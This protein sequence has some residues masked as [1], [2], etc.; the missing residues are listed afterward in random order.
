MKET[1]TYEKYQQ[2]TELVNKR[3]QTYNDF[4]SRIRSLLGV[5]DGVYPPAELYYALNTPE[6][7][8]QEMIRELDLTVAPAPDTLPRYY[9]IS[10][11]QASDPVYESKEIYITALSVKEALVYALDYF[12]ILQIR[13]TDLPEAGEALYDLGYDY[14]DGEEPERFE[15]AGEFLDQVMEGGYLYTDLHIDPI[16]LS[17][18]PPLTEIRDRTD[19]TIQGYVSQITME[20]LV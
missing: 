18:L 10:W 11:E 19:T 6:D 4:T 20:A 13:I 7:V 17:D 16:D 5:A 15:S 3:F 1:L 2:L 9:V 12:N 14:P 8:L